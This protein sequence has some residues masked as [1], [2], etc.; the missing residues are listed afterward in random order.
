VVIVLCVCVWCVLT[1]PLHRMFDLVAK[2]LAV[3][4]TIFALDKAV[5]NETISVEDFVK[6][7]RKLARE[8]FEA[9]ALVN[10]IWLLQEQHAKA[11]RG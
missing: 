7:V 8:Q 5:E 1:L 4:D 11:R 3:E 9:R 2:V 6:S 10:K